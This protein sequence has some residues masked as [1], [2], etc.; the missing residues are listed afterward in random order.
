MARSPFNGPRARSGAVTRR[1]L[2]LQYLRGLA[3]CGVVCYHAANRAGRDFLVGEAGVDLFFI[4]SGFLM[5]VI[6]DERTRPVRF[7]VDRVR[8]IVPAYWIVTSVVLLGALAGLF[9]NMALQPW[10]VV[11]SFL[12]IPSISLS[13]PGR[14]WPLL[15]PGWTLNYEMFF[16]VVFAAVL[17][18]RR[19]LQVPVLTLV[20]GLLVLSHVIVVRHG[21]ADFYT[22]PILLEFVAGSWLGVLWVR[23]GAW[24]RGFGWIALAAA[25]AILLVVGWINTDQ[26]RVLRFGLPALLLVAGV[27]CLERGDRGLP[28]WPLPRL[29]GDASYSIYLWHTLAIGVALKASARFGLDAPLTIALGIF[30]GVAGGVAGYRLIE[31]PILRFFH[32]RRYRHGAPIPAGV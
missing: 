14:M 9:P 27:L 20:L 11:S 1:L 13:V 17:T 30:I 25:A 7:L 6:T 23:P 18:L 2:G 8:R 15:I 3:A 28:D 22:S 19:R 31:Q 16:Y 24:P 10:H 32:A 5:I 21:V 29:L 12:F 4:L 26:A